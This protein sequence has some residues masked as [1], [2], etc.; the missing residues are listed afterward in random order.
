MDFSIRFPLTARRHDSRFVV[1]DTLIKSAHFIHVRMMYQ[2][3]E[4]ARV[5]VN[6]IVTLHGVPRRIIFDQG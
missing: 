2:A 3:P 6:K 4:I 5:F 1:V